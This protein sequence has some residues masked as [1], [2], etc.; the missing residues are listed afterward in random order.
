MWYMIC[1][2]QKLFR[3]KEGIPKEGE[4]LDLLHTRTSEAGL[5]I[6]WAPDSHAHGHHE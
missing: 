1:I 3:K 6:S 5:G 4:G 2:P